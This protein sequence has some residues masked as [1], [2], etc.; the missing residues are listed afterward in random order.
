MSLRR[1]VWIIFQ[2]LIG[3][4]ILYLA[5][6]AFLRWQDIREQAKQELRYL[7][8]VF[9]S[10]LTL[11]FKQQEI[12]L[13]LIGEQM[14]RDLDR[15]TP[16]EAAHFLDRIQ[17][18]HPSLNGLGLITPDGDLIRATS[19]INL[20]RMPNLKEYEQTRDT[21]LKALKSE[22]MVL[23]RTYFMDAF[24]DWVIPLRKAIRDENGRVVAVMAAGIKPQQL[25][26]KVKIGT[27]QR[28]YS[29]I[30]LHDGSFRY[31]YLSGLSN[32]QLRALIPKPVPVRQ[33]QQNVR[34]IRE[35]TGI[36]LDQLRANPQL[37]VEFETDSG[38]STQEPKLISLSYLPDFGAWSL[39]T[40]PT[41][42]LMPS[43]YRSVLLYGMTLLLVG[44]IVYL[45]IRIIDRAQQQQQQQ[46]VHQANHDFLTGLHNRQYLDRNE[47]RW[48]GSNKPPFSV[49]F[50]DL[51]NFKHINDS[52]GHR[53]GDRLLRLAADR[54][55]DSFDG[56][57]LVC[58]QGGDEFIVLS[59]EVELSQVRGMARGLL[60]ALLQPF[61][62][63]DYA[64]RIGAS[65]GI[66]FYP[67]DGSSL[68]GLF[69][70][71]DSAM[72]EAKKKKNSY[73]IYTGELRKEI[74]QTTRI[75][76][77]LRNAIGNGEVDLN[78]QLQVGRDGW[79]CGIEALCRWNSPEL[80]SIPPSV[81]IPIAEHNGSII[82]L[83]HFIIDRAL[84]D[85]AGLA[86]K[87]GRNDL[88]LSI[89]ISVRQLQE[90][91]FSE[92]LL[93]ALRQHDFAPERLTLEITESLFIED[94]EY[95]MPVI[96][97]LREQ[98]IRFALDDFGTGYSSLSMLRR[99]PIDEIKI[100]KSFVDAMTSSNQDRRLV[101]TILT[102]A[103]I[104]EI[105]TIAEGIET[106]E[107]ALL[108]HQKGCDCMQGYF[109]GRPQPLEELERLC[110]QWR[111]LFPWQQ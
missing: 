90:K 57:D 2:V 85:I 89:N 63:G 7:N 75:D 15:Q 56:R 11:N 107:Q 79:P 19:N 52:H 12:M 20:E 46:L 41:R 39:T 28:P 55:T 51:D 50:I 106:E 4:G 100:D 16:S 87:R 93:D 36:S 98:G 35:Q 10:S 80:G 72:Y 30:L 49:W 104:L 74:R 29:M 43:W 111:P 61:E 53:I 73:F 91:R 26:P 1:S 24:Q 71:A 17:A 110:S 44:L 31:A 3:I 102:M 92:Q 108:L 40:L 5:L 62:I 96:D 58:R 81:F 86:R 65:I 8:H 9:A 22:H 94:Y 38:G 47:K 33:I 95:L 97:S 68:D 82:Q 88:R 77:S 83:G 103:Y 14:V 18:L 32:E 78:Y 67:E 105:T 42:A 64:F 60:N 59:R 69:S 70:A 109:F 23:G 37:S 54:I 101:E 25:L 21:F 84:S 66:C 13:Q 6:S 48:I 27:E 99:L 76:Q 34:Y 45:L